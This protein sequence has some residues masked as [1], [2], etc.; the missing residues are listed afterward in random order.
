MK[1]EHEGDITV[2]MFEGRISDEPVYTC[3]YCGKQFD[4][5]GRIIF[6]PETKVRTL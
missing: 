6:D 3:F 1:H 4:K 5:D 2:E